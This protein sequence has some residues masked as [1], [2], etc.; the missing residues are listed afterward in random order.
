MAQSRIPDPAASGE[1]RQFAVQQADRQLKHLSLQISRAVKSCNAGAVHDVRVAIRRFTQAIAVCRAYFHAAD[2]P[3]NRRRLKKFMSGAGEVRNCDVALKFTAKFKVPH[4]V[5]LRSKLQSRRKESERLLVTELKKWTDRRMP[6]RWRAALNSAAASREDEAIHELARRALGR[7]AK[8]FLK[9][10]NEASS[11]EASPNVLHHFRI[12]AKK[13]RYALEL[14][15]PLYDALDPI[16]AS[17]KRAH[18]L[19][20][21]INDCVTVADIISEYKG[22]KPLADRLKKRQH[23]KT[24]EFR[25]YWKEAFSDG[26]RLR[27]DID[28]LQRPEQQPLKK[29]AARIASQH[30][31]SA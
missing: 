4:A 17:I 31:K 13:F 30:R 7:I 1:A 18:A 25:K 14:F 27:S 10:G 9:Q 2:L 16:V 26:E 8:D 22:G 29:P 23:K 3:K 24:E 6:V 15:Q 5:Q 12:V 21:D 19:L 20:G 28:H 11:A